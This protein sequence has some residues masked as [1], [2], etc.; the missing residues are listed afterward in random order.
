MDRRFDA[1]LEEMLLQAEVSP[2][3]IDGLLARLET[4]VLP[5]AASLRA[6]AAPTHGRV[7]DGTVSRIS[8]TRPAKGSPTCMIRNDKASRSSSGMSRGMISPCS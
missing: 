4:F 2:E 1:R 6:R 3:L 8:S 7:P 5:F